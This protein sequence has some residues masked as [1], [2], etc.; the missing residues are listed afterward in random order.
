MENFVVFY[1]SYFGT[2]VK[3]LALKN[4]RSFNFS[5]NAQMDLKLGYY[6][7]KD[8]GGKK[9]PNQQTHKQIKSPNFLQLSVGKNILQNIQFLS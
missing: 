1:F 6:T 3:A 7:N 8:W 4:T 5:S 9:N 2:S